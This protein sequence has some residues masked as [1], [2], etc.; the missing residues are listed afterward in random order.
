[1]ELEQSIPAVIERKRLKDI[2]CL[3]LTEKSWVDVLSLFRLL[4]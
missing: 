2:L 3:K 4:Q 1:M